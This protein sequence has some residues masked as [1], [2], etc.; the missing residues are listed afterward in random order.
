M[1][2]IGNTD[3]AASAM[4]PREKLLQVQLAAW[5][6]RDPCNQVWLEKFNPLFHSFTLN[7]LLAAA[8]S[9][10]SGMNLLLPASQ[11]R[12]DRVK[13]QL[14]VGALEM[15]RSL[16]RTHATQTRFCTLPLGMVQRQADTRDHF[17]RAIGRPTTQKLKTMA[18]RGGLP[19]PEQSQGYPAPGFPEPLHFER[20]RGPQ[21]THL[22]CLHSYP[23]FATSVFHGTSHTT[24]S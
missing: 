16:L 3:S 6:N 13:T 21:V 8:L 24:P 10:Q 15:G 20:T 14:T 11:Q 5:L 18:A 19:W 2:H 1:N 23:T 9:L 22:P 17:L 12:E 4:I 7:L